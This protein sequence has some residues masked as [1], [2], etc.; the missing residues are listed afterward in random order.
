[1][2]CQESI[3]WVFHSGTGRIQDQ[4]RKWRSLAHGL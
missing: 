3:V 4:L 1:V 2:A